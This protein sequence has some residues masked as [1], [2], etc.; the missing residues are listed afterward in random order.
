M[1][2]QDIPFPLVAEKVGTSTDWS[3]NPVFQTSFSMNDW[4]ETTLDFGPGMAAEAS[5]PSN[6]GA[7]F[8]LDIIVLP[9]PGGTRMLW[10]YS[11]PLFTHADIEELAGTYLT[12]VTRAMEAPGTP[13]GEL[14]RR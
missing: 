1:D 6:G 13:L 12:L 11:T 8:D 4:P 5:F 9:D 14:A 3:R 2:H 10:R 7:K